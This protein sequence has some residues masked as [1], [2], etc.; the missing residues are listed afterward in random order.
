MYLRLGIVMRSSF[1]QRVWGTRSHHEWTT[2]RGSGQRDWC[3]FSQAGIAYINPDSSRQEPWVESYRSRMPDELL[4]I[5]QFD[6]LLAA[7][8]VVA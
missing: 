7:Q 8:V 5:E 2:L 4:A 1:A 3:C 6:S